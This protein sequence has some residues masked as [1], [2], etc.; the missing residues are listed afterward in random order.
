MAAVT[1]VLF[2]VDD[3]LFAHSAAE[4]AGVLAYLDE[5]GLLRRF[6][7][8]DAALALWRSLLDVHYARFLDGELSYAA[9]RLE[10]VRHFLAHLGRDPGTVSDDEALA[11]FA[12]YERH[13]RSAWAAF[14]DA[15]PVLAALAPRYALGVVSNASGPH[16]QEKLRAVGLLGHV[17]GRIVCSDE[18]GEAKPA[19]GIFHAACAL[20]GLPP[21]QVAHV[22]DRYDLDA[23]GARDAGLHAFWLDRAAT[24]PPGPDGRGVHVLHTLH[25]L[26]DA[27]AALAAS[28]ASAASSGGARSGEDR[29]EAGSVSGGV[30][31]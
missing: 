6:P 28:A 10:R 26:P 23:A 30:V 13:R 11:W 3:T 1:G 29:R 16:Q 8:P 21:E 14:S 17:E 12:G 2:D 22:G 5:L 31:A 25:A 27:L 9:Q 24:T 20:L 7:E 18:H 15:G 19:P 4:A